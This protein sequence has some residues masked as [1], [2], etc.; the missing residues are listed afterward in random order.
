MYII[1]FNY[2]FYITCLSSKIL[3]S[4]NRCNFVN[5]SRIIIRFASFS[6]VQAQSRG[7]YVSFYVK[8]VFTSRS[9]WRSKDTI[10]LDKMIKIQMPIHLEM[11]KKFLSRVYVY[12][13][14]SQG[15]RSPLETCCTMFLSFV[16][17][18]F[19]R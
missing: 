12:V 9:K 5:W 16:S 4:W 19:E 14:R 6:S 2:I 1:F 18:N 17:S 7:L 13:S 3:C 11:L 15:S 10:V 8:N